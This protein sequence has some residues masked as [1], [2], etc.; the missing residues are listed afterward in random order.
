MT[1]TMVTDARSLLAGT[2]NHDGG[3][4]ARAGQPSE[5]EPTAL[6]ALA[7]DDER[8]SAWLAGH[9]R[10]DG[11]FAVEA[12]PY[13]NDSATALAALALGSGPEG[14]RALDHLESTRAR[15]VPSTDAIPIAPSAIGWAWATGTSS[16][17]E[18]TARALWALRVARPTSA[19]AEDAVAFLR[20]RETVGGGWNY[21]NRVVLDEE[22]PPFAQSTAVALIGLRGSDAELEARGLGALRRLWPVESAGGLSLATALAAFRI[23][24]EA[25]EADAVRA[26]L[27][28][29]VDA[30]R[31][32]DDVVSLGW[33]ALAIGD[34]LMGVR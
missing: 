24:D 31:L 3:F 22:L 15:R 8:A 19:A 1:G 20:D 14:E 27:E 28:D 12:G 2:R 21:G 7:L 13:V 33:A 29:L 9:Q 23:H 26:V 30:T 25:A 16:W 18:P 32:Q 11:S 34:G 17:V 10:P 6:A 4:G 5:A